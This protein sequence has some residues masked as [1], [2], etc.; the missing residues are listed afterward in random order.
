MEYKFVRYM[1]VCFLFSIHPKCIHLASADLLIKEGADLNHQAC[2][3]PTTHAVL[4]TRAAPIPD[5]T[6][7]SST[8]CCC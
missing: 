2:Y 4:M 3:A 8:K 5:F 1:C 7:T 6:N